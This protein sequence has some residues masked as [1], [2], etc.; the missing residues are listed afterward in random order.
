M[1]TLLNELPEIINRTFYILELIVVRLTLLALTALGAYALLKGH[2]PPW[3]GSG[4]SGPAGT[5]R[6]ACSKRVPQS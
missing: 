2:L 5:K 1:P 6:E 3:S 4:L